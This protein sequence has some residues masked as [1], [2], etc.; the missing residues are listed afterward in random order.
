M[1][2]LPHIVQL[3]SPRPPARLRLSLHHLNPLHV[4]T[5][6]LEPHL[7]TNACELVSE[8]H[9]P[10]DRGMSLADDEHDAGEGIA[11]ALSNEED[12]TRLYALRVSRG[13]EAG[14]YASGVE[15]LNLGLVDHG[16][17]IRTR[18]DC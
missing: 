3:R 15:D 18:F 16:Y 9:G 7:H 17:R 12:V 6:D 14:T 8:K 4:R 13:E 10:V 2:W 11:V 1:P 5:V